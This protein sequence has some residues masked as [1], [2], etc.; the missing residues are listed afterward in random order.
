VNAASNPVGRWRSRLAGS[1]WI[2]RFYHLVVADAVSIQKPTK[3]KVVYKFLGDDLGAVADVGCGP[4]VF[5]RYLCAHAEKVCAMD[6]DAASLL[7]VKARHRDQQNL[8]FVVTLV[9]HLPFPDEHFDTILLL[10]VL[11]HLTDDADGLREVCR[12]L[13]PA[14]KLVLSVPVPPGEVDD[15]PWGHKREGYELE[16][17]ASLLESNGFDVRG[18]SYAEFKFSRLGAVL[19]RR[20]RQRLRIPA[21]IFLTWLGYLDH[22]LNAEARLRGDYLPASVVIVAEKKAQL[23]PL[24]PPGTGEPVIIAESPRMKTRGLR[25]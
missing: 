7:R 1:Y 21:P 20:W 2:W 5:T 3:F 13:K 23:F 12:V 25:R 14:G 10:E 19:V 17:I 9:D 11:E 15:T 4:G 8:T 18:H 6:V 16:Q 24:S 22:L